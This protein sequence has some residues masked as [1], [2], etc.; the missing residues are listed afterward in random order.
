[1]ATKPKQVTLSKALIERLVKETPYTSVVDVPDELRDIGLK[2][3]M[4]VGMIIMRKR[5][6]NHPPSSHWFYS[7]AAKYSD[8]AVPKIL[9]LSVEE[10]A[11]FAEIP[12]KCMPYV[13]GNFLINQ[14]SQTTSLVLKDVD[15]YSKQSALTIANLSHCL[16]VARA[17]FELVKEWNMLYSKI[18]HEIRLR[19]SKGASSPHTPPPSMVPTSSS[20]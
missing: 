13:D 3:L 18:M 2:E 1:M 19:Y 5:C 12:V 7:G 20:H 8:A 4:R 11:G 16:L 17:K 15:F 14:L 10:A 9:T 6:K